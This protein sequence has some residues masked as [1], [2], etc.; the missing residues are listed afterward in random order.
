MNIIAR[1]DDW[2]T[3]NFISTSRC[4]FAET[5]PVV[6]KYAALCARGSRSSILPGRN[7]RALDLFGCRGPN[8]TQKPLP[9]RTIGENQLVTAA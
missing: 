6:N 8:A 2:G 4:R 1:D 3:L 7:S 9:T 5:V